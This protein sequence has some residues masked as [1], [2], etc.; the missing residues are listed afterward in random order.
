MV[1]IL[2]IVNIDK[3]LE[4]ITFINKLEVFYISSNKIFFDHIFFN[5]NLRQIF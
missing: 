3:S 2:L 5:I 4:N 1:I